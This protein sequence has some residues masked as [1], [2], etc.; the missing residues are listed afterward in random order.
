MISRIFKKKKNMFKTFIY[1]FITPYLSFQFSK[2]CIKVTT[3]RIFRQKLKELNPILIGFNL[4][5]QKL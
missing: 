4:I 3:N 2:F 1:F 5:G